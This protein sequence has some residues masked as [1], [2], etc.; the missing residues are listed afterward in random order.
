MP[1]F[2]SKAQTVRAV[3]LASATAATLGGL[4]AKIA[5]TQAE[6]LPPLRA[7]RRTVVAPRMSRVRSVGLPIFEIRPRRSLPPLECGRGVNPSQ[8]AKCRPET[9]PVGSGTRALSEA[10]EIGPMPGTVV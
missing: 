4:R 10:A 1:P 8:A 9:N 3:L 6:A 5:A 7:C 2:T